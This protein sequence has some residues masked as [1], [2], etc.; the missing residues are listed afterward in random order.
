[1]STSEAPPRAK[2][3]VVEVYGSASRP[4]STMQRRVALRKRLARRSRAR[5]RS[6]VSQ[7]SALAQPSPNWSRLYPVLGARPL[8]VRRETAATALPPRAWTTGGR[9]TAERDVAPDREVEPTG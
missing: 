6:R 2:A 7:P 3:I 5:I 8:T 1:M 4:L 9:E